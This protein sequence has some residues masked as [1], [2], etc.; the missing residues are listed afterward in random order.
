VEKRTD[1]GSRFGDAWDRYVGAFE[2][3]RATYDQIA[4]GTAED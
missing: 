1:A 3:K 2:A 4:D